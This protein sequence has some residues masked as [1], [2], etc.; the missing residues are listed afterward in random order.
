MFPYFH[1]PNGKE[2]KAFVFLFLKIFTLIV[3]VDQFFLLFKQKPHEFELE[4]IKHQDLVNQK[5]LNKE[6]SDIYYLGSSRTES[7][8]NPNYIK[9][10]FSQWNLGTYKKSN[11]YYQLNLIEYI[12]KH[13]LAKHIVYAIEVDSFPG[14]KVDISFQNLSESV[15]LPFLNSYK[16]SNEIKGY[17]YSILRRRRLKQFP[18]FVKRR[19]PLP[20]NRTINCCRQ[21]LD[22]KT[23]WLNTYDTTANPSWI[24][25]RSLKFSK[26]TTNITGRF[27]EVHEQLTKSG[28]SLTYVIL[29]N[30]LEY[31][32][33]DSKQAQLKAYDEL[34]TYL[35]LF[36]KSISHKSPMVID[37]RF[38]IPEITSEHS[39]YYDNVHLNEKGAVKFSRWLSGELN[40]R[41]FN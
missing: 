19:I 38:F 15:L 37:G 34:V 12:A 36:D 18:R 13:K 29:P 11:I 21:K 26:P 24:H 27:R 6:F 28:I 10:G 30:F 1:K 35:S 8:I 4:N 20:P 23:G 40:K 5:M 32:D 2:I 33:E 31:G 3:I 16:Y 7:G 25:L 17:V 39:F 22:T 41:L 14:Q 9:N